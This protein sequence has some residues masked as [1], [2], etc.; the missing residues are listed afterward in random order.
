MLKRLQQ[1]HPNKKY[2][3][4]VG[5]KWTEKEEKMLLEELNQNLSIST[6]AK[7][8]NRT[9]NGIDARRKQIAYKMYCDKISIHEIMDKTKLDQKTIE[10]LVVTKT[11]TKPPQSKKRKLQIEENET[12][13]GMKKEIQVLKH[14]VQNLFEVIENTKQQTQEIHN[15]KKPKLIENENYV[16]YFYRFISTIKSKFNLLL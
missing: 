16:N 13:I 9:I 15:N 4:N 1:Q 10:D 8:H 11:F 5:Q 12:I 14:Q 6:I 7:N 2:P 3:C